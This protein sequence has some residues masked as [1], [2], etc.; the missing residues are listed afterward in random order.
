M[1]HSDIKIVRYDE[2]NQ[3][4]EALKGKWGTIGE[5]WGSVVLM[6]NCVFVIL[7]PGATVS[8]YCLPSVYDG[9][10]VCSDGSRIAVSD[11]RFT[12]SLAS[13]V[14]GFGVLKLTKDN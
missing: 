9:F 8:D 6:K 7:Y 10:L 5:T 1:I 13:G 2:T 12:C 4:D 3:N 14:S 11:S